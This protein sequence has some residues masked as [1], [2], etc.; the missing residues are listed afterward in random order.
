MRGMLTMTE[1]TKKPYEAPV[2]VDFGALEDITQGALAVNLDDFPVGAKVICPSG[3]VC[4][5]P[6]PL[7]IPLPT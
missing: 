6:G 4:N 3:Q 7:P 2:I 1:T 5:N